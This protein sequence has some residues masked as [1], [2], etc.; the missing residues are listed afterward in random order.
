[1]GAVF[2]MLREL[3]SLSSRCEDSVNEAADVTRTVTFEL[4]KHVDFI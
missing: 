3:N 1:M 4:V 2:E